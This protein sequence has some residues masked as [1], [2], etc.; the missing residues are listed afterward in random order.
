MVH[1]T[2]ALSDTES[3]KEQYP[4]TPVE[5]VSLEKPKRKYT[6][7]VKPDTPPNT[8]TPEPKPKRVMSDEHKEKMRL[9]REASKLRRAEA[10]EAKPVED[11]P[12]EDK[13]EAKP[14]DPP[15]KK[16]RPKKV[17]VV[18]E[19][20][21]KED[22]KEAPVKDKVVEVHHHHYEEKPK[23]EKKERVKKE[24]KEP[25]TPKPVMPLID[26]V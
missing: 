23:K 26:F 10:K 12:V 1:Y 21:V 11:K 14:V 13:P 5:E 3:E 2:D 16:G 6:K 7:R 25:P 9:A 8:P 17:D 20:P 24:K 18:K 4:E 19:V 22:V 15:K